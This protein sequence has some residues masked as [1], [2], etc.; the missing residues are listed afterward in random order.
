M[1]LLRFSALAI[2]LSF[3]PSA[4]VAQD[5][6]K[7]TTVVEILGLRSWTRQMV[8][9]SVAKYQPG[10]SLADHACAIILR[11]SV[12]FADAASMTMSVGGDTSW[13]VLPVVE[14]ALR[15]RVRF[16]TFTSERPRAAA[17]ADIF[18]VLERDRGA[19][20]DLQ[21]PE[22]LFGHADSVSGRAIS[23]SARELRRKVR[24]HN[25][26][27][28]WARAR[29]ALLGDGNP[30]NRLVAA[31]VLS[32]FPQRDSTYYLL[33]D[34]LR[35]TDIG[36]MGAQMVLSAMSRHSPRRVDW[37]PAEDALTALVGGTNPFM[38]TEVLDVLAATRVDPALGLELARA[39]PVLLMDHLT[40]RNPF[41][42]PPAR[43]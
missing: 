10:I 1:R 3:A 41:S 13:T 8:E 14:P 15:D 35:V 29:N 2:A 21:H 22:V 19:L 34:G 27:R 43:R 12:G 28:D 17:W 16:R 6:R 24:R 37:R 30:R 9:D 33:A 32:N 11:D 36:A 18:A 42:P 39:N 4:L 23:A 31:L 38:Y 25:S 40:A 26:A 20:N 5:A 7:G